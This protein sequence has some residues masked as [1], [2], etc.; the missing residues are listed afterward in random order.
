MNSPES[1][2]DRDLEREIYDLRYAICGGEDA[3]GHLMSLPHKQILEIAKD[4]RLDHGEY[5]D[6]VNRMGAALDEIAG[7][8]LPDQPAALDMPDYDWAVRHIRHLRKLALDGLGCE[9]GLYS[10]GGAQ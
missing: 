3:P 9:L 6:R 7:S 4:Q 10:E 5:I 8:P 2:R 1:P